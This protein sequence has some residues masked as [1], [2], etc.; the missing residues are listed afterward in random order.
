M[1]AIKPGFQAEIAPEHPFVAIGDIHGRDD[2]LGNLLKQLEE[3][4]PNLPL[5]FA[6]DYV[7]RG[8]DSAKVLARLMALSESPLKSITCLMGNHETILLDFLDHPESM[9]RQWL[10]NG[11]VATL[12]SFGVS[13]PDDSASPKAARLMRDQLVET[14]GTQMIAW[15][16]SRPLVW[17]SGNVAATHAGADPKCPIEPRRGHGLLWGHPDFLKTPRKDGL[18]IVHGHFIVD[19]PCAEQGRI[20]IDT[21]AYR[22]GRLT[23]AIVE[24]GNVTFLTCE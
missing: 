21:G 14:M 20:S 9:A 1:G 12:E 22:T 17:Q 2:L 8:P 15:L 11:G 3:Q 19:T 6:G 5:V 23:A 4:V 10:R 13:V 24:P 18:W 7:D 16:R